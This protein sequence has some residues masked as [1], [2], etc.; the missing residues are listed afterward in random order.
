[1]VIRVDQRKLRQSVRVVPVFCLVMNIQADTLDSVATC[2]KHFRV[3]LRNAK[4]D[5]VIFYSSIRNGLQLDANVTPTQIMRLRSN[6]L[7][8][9]T[10]PRSKLMCNASPFSLLCWCWSCGV[11]NMYRYVRCESHLVYGRRLHHRN[12]YTWYIWT[13]SLL[14]WKGT[15]LRT[16]SHCELQGFPS[17]LDAVMRTITEIIVKVYLMAASKLPLG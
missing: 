17:R 7:G 8:Y 6:S 1:M 2:K 9:R 16:S 15:N 4:H 13:S 3:H 12:C 5:E 10:Y 14:V 11:H